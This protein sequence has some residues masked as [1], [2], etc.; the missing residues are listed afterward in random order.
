MDLSFLKYPVPEH[1]ADFGDLAIYNEGRGLVL[2]RVRAL[3]AGDRKDR[4][5]DVCGSTVSHVIQQLDWRSAGSPYCVTAASGETLIGAAWATL[6]K[7]HDGGAAGSNLSFVLA[8]GWEGRGIATTLTAIAYSLC[9]LDN[10][11]ITFAN[12]QS[13][14][15]NTGAHHVALR[16]GL[17]RAPEF[18]RTATAPY[19]HRTYSTFRAPADVVA[20]RC[21]RI[22]LELQPDHQA[23]IHLPSGPAT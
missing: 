7:R 21:E 10:D 9:A 23:E 17:I 20:A 22:L 16:L 11:S 15:N 2:P 6:V 1:I 14:T 8:D 19:E 3:L 12:V 18:D 4:F 13:V 5:S